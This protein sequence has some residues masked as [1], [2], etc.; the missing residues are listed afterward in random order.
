MQPESHPFFQKSKTDRRWFYLK[1]S[2]SG[3]F[4]ILVLL[5]LAHLI[6]DKLIITLAIGMIAL[7]TFLSIVAPFFDLPSLVKSNQISYISPFLL[8]Q[9]TAKGITLH[10]GTLLEYWFYL[11]KDWGAQQRK[12]FILKNYLQGLA[13]LC[14]GE[15]ASN[16]KITATTYI[17]SKRTLKKLG[18]RSKPLDGIQLLLMILN[19]PNL[20]CTQSLAKKKLTFPNLTR[21]LTFESTLEDLRANRPLIDGLVE[22]MKT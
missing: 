19:Y 7:S 9:P 16:T 21:M 1:L 3:V 2:L 17:V 10:G 4:G 12:Y 6:F 14:S 11:Q 8:A 20:I 5:S 22:K 15:L 18:F 13:D